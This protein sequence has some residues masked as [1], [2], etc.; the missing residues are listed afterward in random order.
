M[1]HNHVNPTCL[2]NATDSSKHSPLIGFLF[3]SY[4]IYGPY[5]YSSAN[6][7]S[8]SIKRMVPSYALR[9]ITSRQSLPTTCL[10]TGGFSCGQTLNST[11]YGPSLATNKLGAF[12]EDYDYQA[13]LGDL[14]QFNGRY[15]VTP[16]YPQG[17]YAYFVTVDSS[18]KPAFP[19][20]VSTI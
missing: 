20:D 6:D 7:S 5:G 19:F 8:S 13:G 4:P 18:G 11:Y 16:D 17:T 10:P 9:N 14:D 1:Y 2:Y 15:C 3:D 12:L